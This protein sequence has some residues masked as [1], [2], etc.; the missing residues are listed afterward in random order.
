[1]QVCCLISYHVLYTPG[2]T[3]LQNNYIP[4]KYIYKYYNYGSVKVPVVAQTDSSCY[5][6]ILSSDVRMNVSNRF[7]KPIANLQGEGTRP[8]EPTQKLKT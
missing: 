6:T 4:K 7:L 8:K 2:R 5:E 3:I 1:M